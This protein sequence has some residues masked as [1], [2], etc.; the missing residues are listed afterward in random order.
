MLDRMRIAVCGIQQQLIMKSAIGH[1]LRLACIQYE[2]TDQL[3][4]ASPVLQQVTF[5]KHA[6]MSFGG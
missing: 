6:N 5:K 1:M 2:Q 4:L 3:H